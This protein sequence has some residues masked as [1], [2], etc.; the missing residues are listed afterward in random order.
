MSTLLLYKQ[1]AQRVLGSSD[2]SQSHGN[3]G[4]VAEPPATVL[5]TVLPPSSPARSP[6]AGASRPLRSRAT[7]SGSDGVG[8]ASAS[9]RDWRMGLEER[10]VRHIEP[11]GMD[12]K[13]LSSDA[14]A[15]AL[16]KRVRDRRA[17]RPR[18]TTG[19][20]LHTLRGDGPASNGGLGSSVLSNHFNGRMVNMEYTGASLSDSA[21]RPTL[22]LASPPYSRPR[23]TA[24]RPAKGGKRRT[25]GLTIDAA[26]PTV[27]PM[28][29]ARSPFG[30]LRALLST[31]PL[32][33]APGDHADASMYA[34]RSEIAGDSDDG[35]DDLSSQVDTDESGTDDT[36][37]VLS[38]TSSGS[39][40]RGKVAGLTITAPSF[41]VTTTGLQ[42]DGKVTESSHRRFTL[43]SVEDGSASDASDGSRAN[44][45]RGV[46]QRV[47][48]T[49]S[50]SSLRTLRKR[51]TT[52]SSSMQRVNS[53]RRI[54]FLAKVR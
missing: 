8:A 25:R 34:L 29:P 51:L 23:T 52:P 15:R 45:P 32:A 3:T 5:G 43:L 1:Q 42:L 39:R 31:Q 21:D 19:L 20:A 11:G 6:T 30:A 4:S 13:A 2:T 37:S 17:D 50:H 48:D 54:S 38:G 9:L 10:I 14:R 22:V 12:T 49:P 35:K 27:Q 18:T 33:T 53:E 7:G 36:N 16:R 26:S 24:S 41:T 40:R 46:V 28:T 44:S 47:L